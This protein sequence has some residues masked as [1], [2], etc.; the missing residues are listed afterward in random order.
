MA[1]N[2]EIAGRFEEFA[3]L[4]EADDVEYKPRAYRR[5]AENIRA[6][7]VPIA[8]HI[9][10]GNEE[11]L[12]EIDGVGDAISSKVLEYVE[13]GD[14]EELE[15]LR[16]D[17]PIDIADI[18]RIEGVG[19]KTAG[20]LYRELG[21]ET[22]DDLE[23]AAE[24]GEIQEVSGFGPKTEANIRDNID[25]AREVGQRQLLGEARPLADDVLAF[26]ESLEAV[27]RCEVAGSIRRWRETIGDVDVLVG[28]DA[29][30][31]VIESF[32]D[33]GSVD[34]EIESGPDKASV[35]V[36]E[37]RVDLR[38]VVPEEFGSALQYF[39][40]S[41]DHNV[42]LRN[43]AIDRGMKLNEYGAFDVSSVD[44]P[45]AGQRVGERVAGETEASMYDALGLPLIPPELREDRGEIDAAEADALP[46]LITREDIRG[47]FHTHT[48]WSDG[49]T[50]IEAMVD[51]AAEMGYDYYG[52]ADHAEGPGIVG[53]MGLS[54][55]EILEQVEQIREVAAASE[56][57]VFAGIEANIDADGEIGLSEEVI[58]AL[59]VIVAS[60]HS[61]LDQDAATATAR[62]VT[63]I[64][65]PAI[66][67]IGHPSGRMLNERSGLD[68]DARELARAAADHDTALEIN[69]NPRRLDLWGSAVQAALEEAAPI[70]VNTDAHQPSTL[71]YMRWGVHT[72]R[73][74][75]A[76]PADVINT[77]ELDDVREF[78][79]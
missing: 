12:E 67:V 69:A 59:D 11:V 50:S 76:E 25:F 24:A 29:N 68:F 1:T 66:D 18:T 19:P 21:I 28:T 10:D 32:L 5:A 49:N 75:W 39:T 58:D 7:P 44:D 40:G 55:T 70:S 23:E 4:L 16:A 73:R 63:A 2:A 61:A 60:P 74:G 77:W 9:E 20:K 65:N 72:A 37:I 43:Y 6:H 27:E 56:I 8:G 79:H 57:E 64:E 47:D 17:L 36:G 46:D 22:L 31:D 13:T 3:D 62:L 71:E 35:R 52:V 26:L 14:I 42:R 51:A 15:E 45:D 78:L 33:W 48:E 41:K 54:D 38:V 30:E 34:G 53:D